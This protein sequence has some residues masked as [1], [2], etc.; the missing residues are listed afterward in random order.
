[1]SIDWQ[2]TLKLIF[3]QTC[4]LF[5]VKKMNFEKMMLHITSHDKLT[6]SQNFREGGNSWFSPPVITPCTPLSLLAQIHKL[7]KQCHMLS[8]SVPLFSIMSSKYT[9]M[10]NSR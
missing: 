6:I 1:M 8:I 7:T 2:W 4:S 3:C 5:M 10:T 9:D